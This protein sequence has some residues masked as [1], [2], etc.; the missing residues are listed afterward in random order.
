MIDRLLFSLA[1]IRSA[2]MRCSIFSLAMGLLIMGQALLLTIPLTALWYGQSLGSQ[3]P[4]LAGFAACFIARQIIENIQGNWLDTYATTRADEFRARL[5]ELSFA[6]GR[7]LLQQ[8]GT[9]NF[10]T[11]LIEGVDRVEAYIRMVLPRMTRLAIV[12]VM[13]LVLIFISDWVSGIIALLVF[14]AIILQMVLIGHTASLEAGKQHREYQRLANHFIDSLRGID[15][16]KLFGRSH[17]QTENIYESSERFRKATMKTL[18]VATLS[19]AVLDAFSTISIA[20]I[21]VMLGFRLVD[22]SLTLFPAL[23][24]LVLIPDYFKPIREFA[25]DYH[26]SLDGKNALRSITE[27]LEGKPSDAERDAT[28]NIGA[29][30]TADSALDAKIV[31]DIDPLHD[32]PHKEK[33]PRDPDLQVELHDISLTYGPH[34]ALQGISL[35]CSGTQKI[36][37]VGPSG[38][39]KSTL[40][41]ILA[42]LASPTSGSITLNGAP[43][44]S[45]ECDEWRAHV[46][47]IPQNPHIFHAS[48]RD[49]L[50]FYNPSAS[51]DA[52]NHVVKLM[53]LNSLVADLPH[54]LDTIIGEGAHS[55]SGGQEQR[56]AFARAFLHPDCR[57]LI[58]D[59]PTAHL[60]IET[61]LELKER[62]IDLMENKLV[63][64]A[65]HR[66]HWLSV[67]DTVVL[68]REG[69]L[70]AQRTPQEIIRTDAFV[71]FVAQ[72]KG[73]RHE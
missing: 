27:L 41:H 59:E 52:V 44:A 9:G 16:L 19:G 69:A 25:S 51:P 40:T 18:R 62:M 53:E 22:G 67:M 26:A 11:L 64:L 56:I 68:L 65:T 49:N 5:L 12:P 17:S 63:I 1:G 46:A 29:A 58:F 21:A 37:I 15:T 33:P 43:A 50:A 70:A 42:G 39:G 60:D 14:P 32:S 4:Y 35:T 66:L 34:N 8:Q 23:F 2:L 13:L 72:S 73:D 3:L 36:G 45:L 47:Y 31:P 6:E 55:L 38:A 20:A 48:L 30:P 57:V 28:P 7:S 54:G 10:T 71:T 24:V 61:E